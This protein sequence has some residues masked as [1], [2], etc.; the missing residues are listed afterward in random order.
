[1][2]DK[3]KK[4]KKRVAQDQTLW[5]GKQFCRIPRW[6]ML[7]QKATSLNIVKQVEKN[8]WLR[9]IESQC[10]LKVKHQHDT[11]DTCC[12]S[13]DRKIFGINTSISSRESF[14]G[15][16]GSESR[17]F[18]S[19]VGTNDCFHGRHH[20]FDSR[21]TAIFEYKLFFVE[22]K[23]KI[24]N[25][26][27][28]TR[29]FAFTGFI[30]KNNLCWWRPREQNILVNHSW[31]N[32]AVSTDLITR[33]QTKETMC[34]VKICLNKVCQSST[35]SPGMVGKGVHPFRSKDNSF[36]KRHSH[37]PCPRLEDG[38]KKRRLRWEESLL[39][40]CKQMSSWLPRET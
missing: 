12:K 36:H 24:D 27:W 19:V 30:G 2:E 1:M 31:I 22:D 35:N 34:F 20:R 17:S 38:R 32:S 7:P 8:E 6:P 39:E 23:G 16:Q 14:F 11:L 26:K 37:L 13:I 28:Q 40:A 33:P 25:Q 3:K 5:K 21:D 4:K 15:S 29:M 9:S 18:F 10:G